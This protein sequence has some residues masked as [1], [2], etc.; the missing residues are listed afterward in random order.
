M[1]SLN[2]KIAQCV[3]YRE[4]RH[5]EQMSAG[6]IIKAMNGNNDG[7]IELHKTKRMRRGK[8]FSRKAR[9]AA[10]IFDARSAPEGLSANEVRAESIHRLNN[11][12]EHDVS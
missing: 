2:Y 9:S 1:L 7:M 8:K 4:A 3:A 12:N 5:C 6:Y 11:E 10:R